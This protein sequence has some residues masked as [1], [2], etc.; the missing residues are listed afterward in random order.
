M[1]QKESLDVRSQK[2]ALQKTLLASA[3]SKAPAATGKIV[4]A[5][6]QEEVGVPRWQ[7]KAAE[8][9]NM[10]ATNRSSADVSHEER[11]M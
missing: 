7:Q 11:V 5:Y 3:M 8:K 6:G 4:N 9:K 1:S 10:Y 2:A